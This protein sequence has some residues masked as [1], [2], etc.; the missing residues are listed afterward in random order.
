MTQ[1]DEARAGR[2]TDAVRR[3]AEAEAVDAEALSHLVAQGL[4]TVP[5]NVRRDESKALM[6]VGQ[7]LKV[8]VNANIGTS[9]DV[10]SLDTELEKLSVACDAG[11][12]AIMDLSIGGDLAE[13]RSALLAACP[14]TFGTVPIYAAAVRSAGQGAISEMT[15][16]DMLNAVRRDA[17][18]GVD[19]A[20]VHAGVT[21]TVLEAVKASDRV[22]GIVS[23][24]GSLL[25]HWMNYHGCEN[26]FYERFD[27]VLDI[28][29]EHD[30]VL[31]LGDG[32]RPGAIADSFDAPQVAELS[33]LG[34]LAKR[35]IAAGVQVMIEGPGHVPL[36]EVVAQ[37]RLAKRMTGG[38]PLYVLGPL[39]SDIAPG[40]DHI[41][42]AIGGALAAEAGADFL[43]Y[44]TPAEHLRLPNVED[45]RTGVIACRLAAHAAD[46]ARGLPGAA[47]WDREV[48]MLRSARR[49]DELAERVIDPETAR[50]ERS[51]AEPNIDDTCSM[52]GELCAF[53]VAE[54]AE[55]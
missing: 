37:V 11:A 14:V 38:A 29:G 26:P 12:D 16:D 36:N 53:K 18:A 28:C 47:E 54:I 5:A 31:S 19:F 8:K 15:P 41:A 20:T 34:R 9:G 1:I 43:C 52:C 23:R 33:E 40:Y 30:L 35:A 10:C 46:V 50:R 6:A 2:I 27:E 25:A 51:A 7:G 44:L 3:A 13:A 39:V 32:L 48:S 55:Q 45:V 24:G 21:R 42:G 4:A 49:W 22:C 17:E